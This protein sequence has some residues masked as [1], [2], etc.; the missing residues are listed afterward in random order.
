MSARPDLGFVAC[1]EAGV[2]ERQALLLFESIRTYGG[3]FAGCPIYALSPRAGLGASRATRRRLDALGVEYRDE[4]LNTECLDYGS[5]NR[6]VAAAHVEETTTHEVLVVLDSDTLLLRE[7]EAFRRPEDVDVA[8]R[9]VDVKGICTSGPDD[10]LDEYW[11]RLC[12][13]C[14]VD[15]DTIPWI[16]SYVDDARCKA[17][18][19]GGLVVVR[20]ERAILRR[21]WDYFLASV[22]A[23][24]RP[25]REAV[26]LRSST[27]F[28]SAAASRMWGDRKSVV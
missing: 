15:Y 12:A 14:A 5:S 26:P 21:W 25:R 27:G 28:V 4:V 13:T 9:P 16:R 22:R 24:L 3:C 1:I 17:S 6:V 23:G 18:Y 11:R 19:N 2:L 7:P 20:R 8:L 10:P